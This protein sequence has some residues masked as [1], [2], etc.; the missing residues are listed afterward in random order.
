MASAREL[1]E[2][3]GYNQV[4]AARVGGANISELNAI[5]KN[6]SLVWFT[7][8][9]DASATQELQFD[10]TQQLCNVPSKCFS[11]VV[12]LH[13]VSKNVLLPKLGSEFSRGIF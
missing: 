9:F 2:N 1:H 12:S 6:T 13:V 10:I 4:Y 11:P 7:S 3:S 5:A 8:N